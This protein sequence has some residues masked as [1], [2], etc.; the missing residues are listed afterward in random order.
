MDYLSLIIHGAVPGTGE[1]VV[2]HSETLDLC[3][4]IKSLQKSQIRGYSFMF[5]IKLVIHKELKV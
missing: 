2:I 1:I 4:K 3:R 5:V